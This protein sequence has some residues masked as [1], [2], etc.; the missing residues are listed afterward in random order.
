MKN[1]T[2][3]ALVIAMLGVHTQSLGSEI[4]FEE[5]WLLLQ[6]KN[7]AIAAKR[8]NLDRHLYLEQARSSL[9][10]PSITLGANYTLL[11]DDV[12]LSGEQLIDS[13][14]SS[15]AATLSALGL[16]S[17]LGHATSTISEREIMT[18]SIR[19][20]WPIF[21][22]GRINAAQ[23]IASGQTAEAESLLAMEIQAQYEDLARYYFSVVLAKDVLQTRI[24]VEQGLSQ[25]R[26]FAVKL[27]AEGQIARVERL[28]SDASLAKATVDRKKAEKDVEIALSA[29]TQI[30]NQDERV[31]PNTLLFINDQLPPL[32]AFTDQT[33]QTYP[34]L[35]ILDA[36]KK[37]ASSL[38]S[39]EKGRYYPEIYLYGNYTLYE[40][41]SLASELAPDW[42]VGIGVSIPLIDTSGRSDTVQ[43]AH[44]AVL[45]ISHLRQQATRD[46]TVLVEKTYFEAEQAIAEVQG[47]NAS[48]LLARENLRLRSKAFNQGLATSLE[49]VDAELYLASIKT[50]Q[51]V[52]SFNYQM[53]LN[54]LLAISSD[55]KS[56][57]HYLLNASQTLNA[58]EK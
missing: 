52:A 58:E 47:L 13:L 28:Q 15:S 48:L 51:Q 16:S 50:Q 45:Q 12:T 20:V 26:E 38:I 49:V 9:N 18:S 6:K 33:L 34:G 57:N 11:D 29:L 2:I 53:A 31:F 42:L 25:H 43:A 5:A 14:D 7:S 32:S 21:T 4:S 19:A 23:D 36:R 41:E 40:E 30:L 54:K 24:S 37:Q 35:S 8:A 1:R 56:F 44:S 39:A 10:L 17:L 46:L 22:G 55:V 3:L 27:E